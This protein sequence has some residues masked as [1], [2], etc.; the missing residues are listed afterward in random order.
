MLGNGQKEAE[1]LVS[2]RTSE[3]LFSYFSDVCV[4]DCVCESEGVEDAASTSSNWNLGST[5][6]FH[7]DSWLFCKT[8]LSAM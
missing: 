1:Q 4:G 6:L 8:D 7:S 2:K 3:Q 5:S